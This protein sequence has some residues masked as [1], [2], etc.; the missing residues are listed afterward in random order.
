[1][2][3]EWL[4]KPFDIFITYLSWESGG[5][6]RPVLAFI[7]GDDSIDVY[8]ITTQYKNKSEAVRGKFFQINDRAQ[9]GLDKLSYIDTG[10][11]IT[12]SLSVLTNNKSI[13]VLTEGDKQRLLEFLES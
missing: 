11:L 1:M 7:V 12:L 8:Q 5:K 13:G 3:G 6:S 10:T 9:A 4:M 2:G